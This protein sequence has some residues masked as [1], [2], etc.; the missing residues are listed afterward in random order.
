MS[1]RRRRW[2]CAQM[3]CSILVLAPVAAQAQ[4][5]PPSSRP[6]GETSGDIKLPY[7]FYDDIFGATGAFLYARTGLLQKQSSLLATAMVGTAGSGMVLLMARD[8]VVPGFERLFVDPIFSVAY[9][10][11]N[12]VYAS[13][14]PGFASQQAGTNGSAYGNYVT[15]NGLDN[16]AR[17]SFRYLLPIGWGR[18]HVIPDVHLEDGLLEAGAPFGESLNPLA[19]GRT[20][21]GVRPFYRSLTLNSSTGNE[22]E[23]TNGLD[24]SLVWDNRDFAV[25]P[26]AGQ[27]ITLRWSRDFG[28]LD[29]N[30]A[31]TVV[32]G[33]WDQYFSLGS[34]DWFRQRAIALDVWTADSPT[35]TART[36]GTI[37]SR[38][39][40]FEGAHLGGLWRMRGYRFER[41]SDKAAIYY[42]AEYRMIPRWNPFAGSRW[43]RQELGVEWIQLVPFAELGRVAPT[44]S[45]SELHSA[46][47]WDV[48]FGFR[49][50][51]KGILLRLDFAASP[52]GGAVQMMVGQPF[53]F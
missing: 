38:P 1:Q 16:F 39:P 23:K 52:E 47:K 19:S 26:S 6:E 14:N 7:G 4:E 45:L 33:E 24:V 15:G 20:F 34:S 18:N 31:W 29:S 48:G 28:W 41:F 10:R 50:L 27:S 53:Q 43:L 37:A 44:W 17:I 21:I 51:A 11:G 46:M 36:D 42:A 8:L 9:Y 32:A 3:A 49:M 40:P 13:G 25:N 2:I 30:N 22:S 5:A 35:W 12:Y